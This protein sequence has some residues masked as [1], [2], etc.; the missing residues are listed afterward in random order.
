MGKRKIVNRET[1]REG[2]APSEPSPE[3]WEK[4]RK[5][6]RESIP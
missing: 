6:Y 5:E 1:L 3:Y 2:E 4:K